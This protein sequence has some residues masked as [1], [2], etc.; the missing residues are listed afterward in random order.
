MLAAMRTVRPETQLETHVV[1]NQPPERGDLDLWAGDRPL[2][3][4]VARAGG[5]SRAAALADFGREA[6]TA[7][8][9]AAGRLAN[10]Y[11]PELRLFDRGGR[12]LDEVA[13][14]PAYHQLMRFGIGAGYAAVAWDGAAGGH[15]A[16]AA[17]VYLLSQVEPG[18]CCPMTMSYAAVPALAADPAVAAAWVPRLLSRRYDGRR[19]RRRRRRVRRSAWR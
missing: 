10:R 18:V 11:P 6:G 1:E 15:V 13:F 14:H 4:A 3:E 12:R 8:M 16:H 7:E 2:R 9:R 17:M 19:G 5:E